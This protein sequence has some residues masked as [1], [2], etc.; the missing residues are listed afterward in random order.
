[1]VGKTLVFKR[2]GLLECQVTAVSIL[3]HRIISWK[4]LAEECIYVPLKT[5]PQE[6][7]IAS[8]QQQSPDSLSA[9]SEVTLCFLQGLL[10]Q[11]LYPRVA[12]YQ[13]L[14]QDTLQF[15]HEGWHS[16]SNLLSFASI[17]TCQSLLESIVTKI[18]KKFLLCSAKLV[19][20]N[21]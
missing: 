9:T 1:M 20:L 8:K 5:H 4:K 2:P 16:H 15:T 17:S 10:H 21:T 7:S 3:I 12:R 19:Y 13:K 14:S 18:Q 11:V 6:V